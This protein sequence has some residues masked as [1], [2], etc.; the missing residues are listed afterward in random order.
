MDED[1]VQM[2]T[3]DTDDV[4]AEMA[5]DSEAVAAKKK[6]DENGIIAILIG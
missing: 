1:L 3:V 4:Q 5:D 2:E 6:S